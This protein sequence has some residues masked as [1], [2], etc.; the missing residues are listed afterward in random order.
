MTTY[1][2]YLPYY[3]HP[4]KPE[5]WGDPL[6]T[7]S[8]LWAGW[9]QPCPVMSGCKSNIN[10]LLIFKIWYFVYHRLKKYCIKIFFAAHWNLTPEVYTGLTLVAFC[11]LTCNHL[12]TMHLLT[13]KHWRGSCKLFCKLS[14]VPACCP[15]TGKLCPPEAILL[16]LRSR[17]PW[18]LSSA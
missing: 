8:D 1:H 11:C 7:V 5:H 6:G 9:K 2:I 14:E 17:I 16:D 18:L 4:H 15:G 12:F 3:V 10:S 13:G